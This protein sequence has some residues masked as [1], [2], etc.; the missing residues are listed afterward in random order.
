MA[1]PTTT[2]ASDRQ[3]SRFMRTRNQCTRLLAFARVCWVGLTFWRDWD[4]VSPRDVE[5]DNVLRTG[6]RL[7]FIIFL[8]IGA[9]LAQTGGTGT[10]VGNVTDS[11]RSEEHTSELQ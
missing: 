8:S 9:V 10:L 11:T 2:A 7:G 1:L 5:E 4:S 6:F 3:K